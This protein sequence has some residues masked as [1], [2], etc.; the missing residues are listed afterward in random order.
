M[1]CKDVVQEHAIS[2]PNHPENYP[3]NIDEQYKVEATTRGLVVELKFTAFAVEEAVKADE[4]E[5]DWVQVVD[6]DGTIL[7]DKTCGTT[8]PGTIT[9]NTGILI[10][11]FHTDSSNNLGGFRAEWNEVRQHS[12][13]PTIFLSL[14]EPA[15]QGQRRQL[16]R[17]EGVE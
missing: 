8:N 4:C 12:Y 6:G 9:S 17:L 13:Y 1:Y 10:V 15:T 3:A 11:N 16:G 7:M 14:G 5:H 2:S